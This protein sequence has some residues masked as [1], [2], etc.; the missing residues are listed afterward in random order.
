MVNGV[1]WRL[2][3]WAPRRDVPERYSPWETVNERFAA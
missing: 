1:L 3:T 2:R